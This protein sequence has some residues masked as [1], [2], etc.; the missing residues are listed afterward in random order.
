MPDTLRVVRAH[1]FHLLLASAVDF[2]SVG[3]FPAGGTI[4]LIRAVVSSSAG[5]LVWLGCRVGVAEGVD[6]PSFSAG[7][8]LF[9]PSNESRAGLLDPVQASRVAASGNILLEWRPFHLIVSG[10][11]FVNFEATMTSS[12]AARL[13]IEVLSENFNLLS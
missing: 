9:G 4:V 2:W 8:T 5:S 3:T 10:P 7:E 1:T 13:D 12:G 6:L 11:V